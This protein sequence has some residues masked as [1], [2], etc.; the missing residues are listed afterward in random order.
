M[1]TSVIVMRLR[2]ILLLKGFSMTQLHCLMRME[3][4]SRRQS[5]AVDANYILISIILF[6][7]SPKDFMY[8]FLER[9]KGRREGEKHQCVVASCVSPTGSLVCNPGMC[10]RL[11]IE[12]V[13]LWFAGWHSIHWATPARAAPFFYNNRILVWYITAQNKSTFPGLPCSWEECSWHYD[14]AKS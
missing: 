11:E 8:L 2:V 1:R 7:F 13:T 14:G 6:F 12:L 3:R 9:G 10:P 4:I 5:L